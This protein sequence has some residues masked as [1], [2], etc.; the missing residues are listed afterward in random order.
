MT[1]KRLPIILAAVLAAPFAGAQTP[2][3]AAG[4]AAG[5]HAPAFKTPI[6]K[7][8]QL[9]ALLAHPE[10]IVVIDLRRPDEIQSIGSLPVYLSIQTADLQNSLGYIPKGRAVIT[11]SNHAGRAGKAGDTLTDAGFKV[12][13]AVGVQFYEKEGGT[14]SKIAPPPKH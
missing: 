2:E 11:V 8:A 3:P 6:L 10:K 7:R 9:D 12:A 5:H 13:G 1:V 14:L 4:A